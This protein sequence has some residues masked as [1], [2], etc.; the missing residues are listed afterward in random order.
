MKINVKNI[1][2]FGGITAF[3]LFI[4]AT[5]WMIYVVEIPPEPQLRLEFYGFMLNV[6]TT[7]GVGYLLAL[8]G[9]LIPHILAETKY[10]FDKRKEGQAM[11]SQAKTGIEYL[12][13]ALAELNRKE[14][15]EHLKKVHN[16]KHLV[17][18]YQAD[19][20]RHYKNWDGNQKYGH[21]KKYREALQH[22]SGW[23]FLTR[24]EKLKMLIMVQAQ[25]A[26]QTTKSGI[27]IILRR[28]NRD[29]CLWLYRRPRRGDHPHAPYPRE[30]DP[31]VG[32][33]P[34][35]LPTSG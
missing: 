19:A 25:L 2:V 13:Y 8:L 23:D 10:E 34:L 28:N 20:P 15:F 1:V 22:T 24:D 29:T 5:V 31:S 4:A 21:I 35:E 32:P 12:P 6:Y 16:D 3:L 7:I 9:A 11:F 33:P 17:D 27:E 30:T 18:V 14:G 26:S